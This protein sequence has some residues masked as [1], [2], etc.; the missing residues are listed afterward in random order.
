MVFAAV[1]VVEL[2]QI[3]TSGRTCPD[4]TRRV[5]SAHRYLPRYLYKELKVVMACWGLEPLSDHAALTSSDIVKTC[6]EMHRL[7]GCKKGLQH[8]LYIR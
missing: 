8:T 3:R 7:L 4:D 2:Q 1:V 6:L 5:H